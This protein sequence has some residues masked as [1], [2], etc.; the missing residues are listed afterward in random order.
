MITRLTGVALAAAVAAGCAGRHAQEVPARDAPAGRGEVATARVDSALL[1]GAARAIARADSATRAGA[2]RLARVELRPESLSLR[3]GARYPLSSLVIA[4]RD[5]AG[6]P[7]AGIV[8][9]YAM[10]ARVARIT[11]AFE[12]EGV[13]PGNAELRVRAMTSQGTPRPDLAPAVVRVT[14]VP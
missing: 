4:F 6:A 5:S 7:I 2:A 9:L 11:E 3:V 12:L 8:P 13:E 14:I 1:D 10:S